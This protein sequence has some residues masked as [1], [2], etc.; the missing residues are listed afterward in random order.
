MYAL[1]HPGRHGQMAGVAASEPQAHAPV[2]CLALTVNTVRNTMKHLLAPAAATSRSQADML[3]WLTLSVCHHQHRPAVAALRA[4]V[5][6]V[7]ALV[8]VHR[9]KS[10]GNVVC[11][12]IRHWLLAAVVK[13]VNP[14]GS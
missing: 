10:A 14:V 5:L 13:Q 9:H 4:P 1:E 12:L 7:R 6:L 11:K 8:D 3:V 2:S